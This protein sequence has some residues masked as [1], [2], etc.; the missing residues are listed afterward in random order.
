MSI[1]YF[2]RLSTL[3]RIILAHLH[4]LG[5]DGTRDNLDQ[6]ASNGGLAGSVVENLVF[7][8]HLAGVLGGV[9]N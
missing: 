1:L 3:L 5:G 9:L 2:Y 4:V 6:F 8:N 7:A